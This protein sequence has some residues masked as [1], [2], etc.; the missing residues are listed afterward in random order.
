[1][2]NVTLQ[3]LRK[4][5]AIAKNELRHLINALS[6]KE[7]REK[8]RLIKHLSRL[9]AKYNL[10]QQTMKESQRSTNREIRGLEVMKQKAEDERD[11]LQLEV[12]ELKQQ[13]D[14]LLAYI[15]QAQNMTVGIPPAID[16][17]PATE[18]DTNTDLA[19]TVLGLVG[20]HSTTRREVIEELSKVHG[21]K[22]WVE[23]PPLW[24]ATIRK[25]KLRQKLRKC[26]L[27]VIIADYMSHPLFH[28]VNGLRLSGV[29]VAEVVLLNC[30][31]KSGVIR[32]ILHLV[33][34]QNDESA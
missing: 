31:G 9:Q 33:Q 8:K 7:R 3:R 12:W 11:D 10:L 23:I 28:A 34:R 17:A 30:H 6:G 13:V 15:A 27:I 18:E 32:E 19:H 25:S 16:E 24:E 14:E 26:N 22:H 20:G 2:L 29:L 1:M 21:L 4:L 5:I